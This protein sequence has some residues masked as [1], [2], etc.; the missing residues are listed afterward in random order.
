MF[1]IENDGKI[2]WTLDCFDRA[3]LESLGKRFGVEMFTASDK[4]PA[5]KP[6]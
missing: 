6:G 4:V 2:S 1:L 3:E 5:F